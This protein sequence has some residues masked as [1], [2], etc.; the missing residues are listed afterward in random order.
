VPSEGCC[1]IAAGW[2]KGEER[3]RPTLRERERGRERAEVAQNL[4][5]TA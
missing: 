5:Y 1:E 4:H 3:N 2:V